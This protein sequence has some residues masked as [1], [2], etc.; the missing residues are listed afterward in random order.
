MISEEANGTEIPRAGAVERLATL[1]ERQ[2]QV[3]SLRCQGG[4]YQGMLYED[5]AEQIGITEHDVRLHLGAVYLK[6]G[7]D[8]LSQGR[9]IKA[10]VEIFCPLLNEGRSLQANPD[11]ENPI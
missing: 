1:T 5:I 11:V 8:V 2:R 10:L 3:L 7:L 9:R 4:P 6:L